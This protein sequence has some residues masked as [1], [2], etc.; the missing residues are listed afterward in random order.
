VAPREDDRAERD[1]LSATELE[2][3]SAAGLDEIWLSLP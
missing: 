3:E 1:V 2:G